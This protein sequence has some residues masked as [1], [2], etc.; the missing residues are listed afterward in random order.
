[1][2]HG[3]RSGF[4][5]RQE[6]DQ[7]VAAMRDI[8][9]ADTENVEHLSWC[10]EAGAGH[11]GAHYLGTAHEE[12]GAAVTGPARARAAGE[13][14]AHTWTARPWCRVDVRLAG[15][16]RQICH[17]GALGRETTIALIETG[18]GDHLP[19]A[20]ALV[21]GEEIEIPPGS[22]RVNDDPIVAQ[23]RG[24]FVCR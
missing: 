7:R 23:I 8:E 24:G 9:V 16:V 12:Q 13:R 5:R 18:V 20:C 3:C 4:G 22:G 21:D 6:C 19:R 14:D 10:G 11:V 15:L 2:R 1:R 17:P